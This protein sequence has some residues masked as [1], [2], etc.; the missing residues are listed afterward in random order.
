MQ[1]CI[2]VAALAASVPVAAARSPSKSTSGP[3]GKRF[4]PVHLRS[5]A[6]V[7][8]AAWNAAL[9]R[10]VLAGRAE[11]K[12][13]YRAASLEP[14]AVPSIWGLNGHRRMR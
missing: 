13:M 9:P 6:S 7:M 5:P 2:M 4:W 3:C 10:L 11:S 14:S 8:G 1:I 12:H